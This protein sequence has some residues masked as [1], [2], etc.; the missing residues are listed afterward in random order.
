VTTVTTVD[1]DAVRRAEFPWAN[2]ALYFDAAS[3]GPLPLRSLRAVESL[4]RRKHEAYRLPHREMGE[5]LAHARAALARLVG[6]VPEE[7]A[8]G[9]N[10]THGLAL[11]ADLLTRPADAGGWNCDGRR[12]ILLS[13][14]EFP[15]NV[16]PWMALEREG[17][18]CER[19]PC[20]GLGRPDEP[21]ML[22]RL[23]RGDVAVLAVSAVQFASGYRADLD[24]LGAACA[25]HGTMFVVDAIQALGAVPLDV[26]GCGVDILACGGQ[27]W[28][29]GPF[30]SG[31]A[32][33]RR[34]LTSVIEPSFPGWT[35]FTPSADFS[36]LLDYR[37]D[38]VAD[39]RRFELGTLGFQEVAGLTAAVE[40]ILEIGVEAIWR[41]IQTV[42][43]PILDWAAERD[44]VRVASEQEP[45]HRSG[46][47]SLGT[48]VPDQVHAAL[49][50]AG[51]TCALREGSV[52][53]S[54]HFYNTPAEGE[55]VATII[56]GAVDACAGS[57]R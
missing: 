47:L 26:H 9:P 4:S 40:L 36:R 2:R 14:R 42:Q 50:E 32:Y 29:C 18:H 27:K 21:A 51:V 7:I 44:D 56:R 48:P 45:R 24:A 55:R 35:A 49:V 41:R 11:A 8:L 39:A 3:F 25:R 38:L 52:R 1:L 28:L 19:L 57:G 34:D 23:D 53:L 37:Y 43:Q 6:A 15:A 54:P 17:F 30:G 33:L 16:Y 46:I 5:T 13:D 22:E 31:F 12:T 10:T 20:D